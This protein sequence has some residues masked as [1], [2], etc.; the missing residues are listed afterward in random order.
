VVSIDG[1]ICPRPEDAKVSVFD[2]GFLYGDSVFEVMRTYHGVPF[3]ERPHLE[4]LARS[5]ERVLIR[6]PIDVAAMQREVRSALAEAG[7]QESYVR[8]IVSRGAG[9]IVL[10][11]MSAEHPTRVVIVV[12]L[13][14][15]PDELYTEGVEVALVRASRA[16]D[17]TRAAGAKA[18]N[19]LASLLA[20]HEA[21]QRGGYE[22][23]ITGP[24]GE[25]IEGASSNV[26]VVQ[27]GVVRTPPAATGL[28]EGITRAEVL[29]AAA[30]E[31]ITVAE[32]SL[33]P[34]D[35]YGADEAFLTSTLREV[36]PIVR[37][38][39]HPVGRGTP[40]PITQRL[41]QAYLRRVEAE[42]GS[43]PR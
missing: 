1:V 11:P 19:Y 25:I 21:K 36:V 26:F 12:P 40:G 23:I 5:C 2:R 29:A 27:H 8:V 32:T 16:T 35:L 24:T 43:T 3:G 15:Q 14:A 7:A 34:R 38:D 41:H 42:C 4:R 17:D 18:S 33:D 13:R 37:A 20:V 30:T 22:A 10:D 39:G 28:L 9:P 6:M 31:G